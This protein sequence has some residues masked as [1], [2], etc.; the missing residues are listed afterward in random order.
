MYELHAHP[1]ILP[2]LSESPSL[3]VSSVQLGFHPDATMLTEIFDE[4]DIDQDG[5]GELAY[6]LFF[7]QLA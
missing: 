4:V 1:R 2:G 6:L 5:D 3:L 7:P